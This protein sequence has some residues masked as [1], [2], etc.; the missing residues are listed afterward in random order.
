MLLAPPSSLPSAAH[1]EQ[2]VGRDP[3]AVDDDAPLGPIGGCLARAMRGWEDIGAEQWVLRVLRKGYRI[4]FR[5]IPPLSR[6]PQH[7]P[8]YPAF[9]E[10]G[11]ALRGEVLALLAKGAVEDAP[12]T[13]GFYSRVFVVPK[14]TGGFRPVIDLSRLN[15]YIMTTPFKMETPQTVLEAVRQHDWMVTIDLKDAYLQVPMHP[16]SHT[17]L[18]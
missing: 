1:K 18:L 2:G 14:S 16:W 7:L 5:N 4:P 10:R 17:F 12:S 13:P 15:G 9:S 3:F 8:S 6:V 11:I